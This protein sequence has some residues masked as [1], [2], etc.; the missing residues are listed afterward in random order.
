MAKTFFSYPTNQRF[1][2]YKKA[3]HN[4][5]DLQDDLELNFMMCFSRGRKKK[6]LQNL[7]FKAQMYLIFY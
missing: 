5:L 7:H 6:I 4:D 3:S 2:C 1:V